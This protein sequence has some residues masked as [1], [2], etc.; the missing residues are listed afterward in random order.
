MPIDYIC[1]CILL[2]FTTWVAPWYVTLGLACPLLGYNLRG[3]LR[4]DH[5]IY[6][7]TRKEYQRD[8]PKMENQF[9]Y[10]SIYYGVLTAG[11]LVMMILALIDFME[12]I[13]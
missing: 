9:K 4:K 3:Y 8:F 11:S 5:K 10:K 7:I 1:S 2:L 13:V 12:K 6:F